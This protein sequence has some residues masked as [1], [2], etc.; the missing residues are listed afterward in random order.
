MKKIIKKNIKHSNKK[1]VLTSKT[2]NIKFKTNKKLNAVLKKNSNNTEKIKINSKNANAPSKRINDSNDF[3]SDD[4]PISNA[5]S[6][7]KDISVDFSGDSSLKR[8]Y[9]KT[10]I[11]GFDTLIERG[12]PAGSSIIISGGPGTG[13]TILCL[14]MCK[15]FAL[16]GKKCLYMSFEE[17]KDKLLEH[18]SDFG[19]SPQELLDKD[20]LRIERFNI[21]D[22]TRNVDAL[23]AK[24]KGELLIDINPVIIPN[25]FKPDII[26]FDSLTAVG[27]AFFGKQENYRVYLE[28]LFRFFEKMA[29]TS[30]LITEV[31]PSTK[32]ISKLGVEEF[33]SDGVIMLYNFRK[34]NLRESALEILKLRGSR[35]N[36]KII[37]MR[38][39]DKGIVIYPDHEIYDLNI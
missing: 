37:S 35:H 18:M 34:D 17:Q 11:L 15:N 16:Q 27:S 39:E 10:N 20:L 38:I 23:L 31:E 29:V 13:K 28:Q 9:L 3:I 1:T 26:I 12:I 21:F 22:V 14:Q 4:M 30:F 7:T 32:K 5:S 2:K 25:D 19:W 33:L 8:N 6:I 24:Q 36:K